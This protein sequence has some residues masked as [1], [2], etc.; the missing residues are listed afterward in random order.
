MV[1]RLDKRL[2]MTVSLVLLGQEPLDGLVVAPLDKLADLVAHK[3]ELCTGV[4]HLVEGQRAQAGKLAP[5]VAR[6]AADQRALAVHALVVAARANEVF[7]KGVHDGE[8]EQA[9]VAG[10]PRKIGLHEVQGVVHPAHVPLVVE[11]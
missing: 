5:P 4:C 6:H 9:V 7:G 10:T 8:R 2:M 11:A 1:E 3:V